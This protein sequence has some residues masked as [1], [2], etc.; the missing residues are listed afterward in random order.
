M[1]PLAADTGQVGGHNGGNEKPHEL[2]LP[3]NLV[4]S[5]YP[6]SPAH[7]KTRKALRSG[8]VYYSAEV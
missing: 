6:Q 1:G 2:R 4:C 8:Q 3:C 5:E 7:R